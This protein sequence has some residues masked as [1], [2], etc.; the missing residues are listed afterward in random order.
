[1]GAVSAVQAS[2]TPGPELK[3]EVDIT[4]LEV[5]VVSK[6]EADNQEVYVVTDDIKKSDQ[7]DKSSRDPSMRGE[8]P[9]LTSIHIPSRPPSAAGPTFDPP[10]PLPPPPKAHLL[11]RALSALGRKGQMSEGSIFASCVGVYAA[12][13]TLLTAAVLGRSALNACT[14]QISHTLFLCMYEYTYKMLTDSHIHTH[15]Y[16]SHSHT[17]TYHRHTSWANCNGCSSSCC[18][19][20]S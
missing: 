20:N 1:M 13:A 3:Q 18:H 15:T 7:S 19:G 5:G 4:E 9:S 10:A 17:H 14:L 16:P 8:S 2:A 11:Q 6:E 12:H